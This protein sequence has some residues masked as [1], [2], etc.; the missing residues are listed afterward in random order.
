MSGLVPLAAGL[1]IGLAAVVPSTRLLATLLFGVGALDPRTLTTAALVLGA[2]ATVAIWV[3]ARR[4][5]R[6]QPAEALRGE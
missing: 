3:P 1:A 2:V 6:V 4:A 5:S